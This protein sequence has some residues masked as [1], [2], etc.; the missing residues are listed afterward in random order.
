MLSSAS[1]SK[2]SGGESASE[3]MP[4]RQ[5]KQQ[6]KQRERA[7]F[8]FCHLMA[9]FPYVYH[10]FR[11]FSIFFAPVFGFIALCPAAAPSDPLRRQK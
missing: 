5:R 6:R 3:T 10:D 9:Y 11:G 7:S 4:R 2:A 8:H 1:S